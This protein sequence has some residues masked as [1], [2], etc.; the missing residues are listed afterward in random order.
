MS[1][2]LDQLSS[3]EQSVLGLMF[4]ARRLSSAGGVLL[5]DEPELHLHPALHSLL[6]AV[7][8]EVADRAQIWTVSHS[9]RLVTA[10]SAGALVHVTPATAEDRNQVARVAGD[11][12][13]LALLYDLGIDPAEALQADLLLIVE[14]DTDQDVEPSTASR[15]RACAVR[16]RRERRRS[17]EHES[18]VDR[19]L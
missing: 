19:R 5:I 4:Y 8:G 15:D 6:F 17:D 11:E 9:T 16:D 12:D 14:G 7:L 1:H 10:A 3:G 18:R 13:R 2:G